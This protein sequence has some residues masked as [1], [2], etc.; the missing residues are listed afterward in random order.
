MY[1]RALLAAAVL[2]VPGL[3]STGLTV[4][5]R[6]ESL[7]L[8]AE[9]ITSSGNPGGGGSIAVV[10]CSGAS[11]GWGVSGCDSPGDWI[12]WRHEFLVKSCFSDS[13]RSQGDLNFARNFAV[14]YI[15]DPPVTTDAADTTTSLPGAGIG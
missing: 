6:S 1:R 3:L 4:P 14:L 10:T 11:N 7:R 9:A 5:A 12:A 8:E 2:C 13:L 15:P